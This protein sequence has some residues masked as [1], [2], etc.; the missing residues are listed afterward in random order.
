MYTECSTGEICPFIWL[1]SYNFCN[2]F[3]R[4]FGTLVPC[5]EPT[6]VVPSKFETQ[7][8]MALCCFCS[9]WIWFVSCVEHAS[10]VP[11]KGAEVHLRVPRHP[12]CC[13]S[14]C[15]AKFRGIEPLCCK[16]PTR[17]GSDSHPSL[18]W[19]PFVLHLVVPNTL[20]W[21]TIASHAETIRTTVRECPYP[22]I[23]SPL[24]RRAW[25]AKCML[26][27]FSLWHF[28]LAKRNRLIFLIF[29]SI[30]ICLPVCCNHLYIMVGM[31]VAPNAGYQSETVHPWNVE[32]K[33]P[34][35]DLIEMVL[36]SPTTIEWPSKG[37]D[38]WVFMLQAMPGW[39]HTV[40]SANGYCF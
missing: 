27:W 37:M 2:L 24:Q 15:F 35:V 34:K 13:D 22:A 18:L 16:K 3:C 30:S 19:R 10:L 40:A 5:V 6:F 21:H 28:L 20:L 26:C 12:W 9:L 36:P 38:C 23:R 32:F 4:L 7:R 14:P 25:E 11:T 1:R 8:H 29:Q 33:S 31:L 39:P 17:A